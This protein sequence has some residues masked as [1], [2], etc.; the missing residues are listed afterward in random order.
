MLNGAAS[1]STKAY[2]ELFAW[3]C[4]VVSGMWTDGASCADNLDQFALIPLVVIDSSH[5]SLFLAQ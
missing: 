5:E 4:N 1:V 3:R 2:N